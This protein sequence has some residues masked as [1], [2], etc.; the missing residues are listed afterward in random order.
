MLY[1]L[2]YFRKNKPHQSSFS[3]SA[4]DV[5]T[6]IGSASG[7]R[8]IRTTEGVRQQIYSLPHLATLVSS[9]YFHSC[10]ILLQNSG[11]DGGI[12]THDPEITNHVLW[13]TELHRHSTVTGCKGRDIFYVCKF[14]QKFFFKILIFL[15]STALLST[16]KELPTPDLYYF[17][18][19]SSANIITLSLIKK[20]L[21]VFFAKKLKKYHFAIHLYLYIIVFWL[22]RP[23]IH[24]CGW[25]FLS[26]GGIRPQKKESRKGI[27]KKNVRPLGSNVSK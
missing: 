8:W 14:F 9:Q 26:Q 4:R 19:K 2:S 1:Q 22:L 20:Q 18:G 24:L 10:C 23:V 21:N 5:A 15:L 11:A 25:R 12:R 6:P 27:N 13:P 16:F 17:V 7:K 3:L